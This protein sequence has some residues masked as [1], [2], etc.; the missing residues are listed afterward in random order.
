MKTY[1]VGI[2]ALVDLNVVQSEAEAAG[3][4]RDLYLRWS[5]QSS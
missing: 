2:Q 4:F 1:E 3:S 5:Q